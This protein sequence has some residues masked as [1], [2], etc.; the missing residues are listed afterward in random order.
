MND[1]ITLTGLV[2]TT[3]RHIRNESGHIASFRL[4]TNNG[5]HDPATSEWVDG[6]TNWYTV[7]ARGPLAENMTASLDKGQRVIVVGAVRVRDW[8]SGVKTGTTIEIDAQHV[9][10]DLAYAKSTYSRK[11]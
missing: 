11:V 4:A 8:E 2:A 7:V 1:T 3:P 9:G 10:H 5:Y 6:N